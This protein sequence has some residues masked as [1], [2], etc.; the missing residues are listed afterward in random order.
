MQN[1]KN[2]AA[3]IGVGNTAYGNFPHVDE[4]GLAAEAFRNAVTDCGIDTTR[5]RSSLEPIQSQAVEVIANL[6]K[7]P[8]TWTLTPERIP[9]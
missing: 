1:L 2:R 3:V 9:K 5:F 7:L 6:R 8:A 4:Y